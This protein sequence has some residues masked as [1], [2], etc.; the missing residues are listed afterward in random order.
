MSALKIP[1]ALY[2]VIAVAL[3]VWLV[4]SPQWIAG[5][6]LAI[7]VVVAGIHVIKVTGGSRQVE[8]HSKRE[9]ETRSARPAGAEH[10]HY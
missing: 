1:M 3:I 4:V 8:E 7:L 6:L 5:A 9:A 10:P 2:A